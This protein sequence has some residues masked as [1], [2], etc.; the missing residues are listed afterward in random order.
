MLQEHYKGFRQFINNSKN[1]K[2]IKVVW[3]GKLKR[4]VFEFK[5]A[6]W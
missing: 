4:Y 6:L 3:K 1:K 5:K 2:N